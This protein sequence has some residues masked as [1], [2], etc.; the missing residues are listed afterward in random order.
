MKEKLLVVILALVSS[1]VVYSES[2]QFDPGVY[3]L[4]DGRINV[5]SEPNLSG[6]IIGRLNVNTQVKIVECVF[7]EQVIDEVSAYWYKIDF[8]NSHGYIWGGYIAIKTFIHD[9][10]K[11]G[12]DDYFHYRISKVRNGETLMHMNSDTFIYINGNRIPS[13]FVADNDNIPESLIIWNDCGI[14]LYEYG[15]GLMDGSVLYGFIITNADFEPIRGDQMAW[16]GYRIDKNGAINPSNSSW[17]SRFWDNQ[18]RQNYYREYY[19]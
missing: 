16:I 10:D 5:R 6:E 13:N 7:N 15:P 17:T 1:M 8:N 18:E 14:G 11:N 9:I 12:V 3:Y 2:Y 19:R 4:L